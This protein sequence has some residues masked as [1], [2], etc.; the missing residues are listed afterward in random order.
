MPETEPVPQPQ[1]A[2]PRRAAPAWALKVRRYAL[3]AALLSF[4]GF[5]LTV[6]FSVPAILLGWCFPTALGAHVLTFI[7][8]LCFIMRIS[9]IV[10]VCSFAVWLVISLLFCYQFSLRA[11]MLVVIASAAGVTVLVKWRSEVGLIVGATILGTV[12]AVLVLEVTR[13]P[14]GD[15]ELK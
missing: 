12:L 7:G 6:L 14:M 13:K 1:T 11:L 4:L 9:E 3:T 10:G 8:V 15:Q 2:E 5:G